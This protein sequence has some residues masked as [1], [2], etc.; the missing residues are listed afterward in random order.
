MEP[1]TDS[2]T[3]ATYCEDQLRR[4]DKD[5]H[6][7]ALLAPVQVRPSLMAVLAFNLEVARTRELTSEPAI[8]RI[9][10]QWW[11][12]A[13]AEIYGGAAVRRHPVCAAL[14]SAI[15]AHALPRAPFDQLI[16]AREH[17]LNDERFAT[18]EAL[19]AYLDGT[20][21]PVVRLLLAVLGGG[22]DETADQLALHA[23]RAW[24]LVGLM[25]A[26]PWSIARRRLPL[27]VDELSR[28]ELTP[29]M[30]IDHGRLAV[31]APVLVRLGER[32]NTEIAAARTLAPRTTGPVR[33]AARLVTLAAFYRRQLARDGWRM[34]EQAA[35]DD[36]R[37]MRA[38]VWAMLRRTY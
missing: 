15:S 31:L 23:G 17:D 35:G 26:L 8:G 9:R 14:S 30:V 24:G 7:I 20:S 34:P 27:P 6:R 10:L 13:V 19:V 36:P 38:L 5:R 16:D 1:V 2:Q 37:A 21:V 32:T 3:T 4:G 33:V 18:L 28:A 29:N 12:D 25:R 22:D 11:R